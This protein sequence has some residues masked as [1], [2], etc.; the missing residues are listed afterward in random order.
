MSSDVDKYYPLGITARFKFNNLFYGGFFIWYFVFMCLEKYIACDVCG[1][2]PPSF[3][4][5]SVLYIWPTDTPS[6]QNLIL[7]GLQQKLQK[8]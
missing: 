5:S 6:M 3:E 2:R 1:L 4:S 7:Q 8:S